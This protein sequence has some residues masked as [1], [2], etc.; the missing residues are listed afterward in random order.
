MSYI[1]LDDPIMMQAAVE[2]AGSFFKNTPPPVFVDEIQY[3]PN[4]FPYVKMII[5]G[6]KKKGQFYFSGS[7]QFHMMKNVSESL[8]GRIG[9]ANMLGLSL[10]EMKGVAFRGSFI[11]TEEYFAERRQ[12]LVP[13]GYREIWEIIHRGS[14]PELTADENISRHSFYAAYARTYVERD[15]RDLAQV[16]DAVAFMKFM[17]VIASMTG[18]LLNLSSVAR[19]V[20]ISAPTAERGLSVL[21][22]SDIV[23][24]LRPYS[25]NAVKRAVKTP[26]IYFLDTGL[27]AYLT[28]WTSPEVMEAEPAAGHNAKS[29]LCKS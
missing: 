21:A 5:D 14:M 17:A 20:G 8:A 3:A 24:L 1:T 10:R 4:L 15:V 2:E 25:N 7:Q 6:E 27:A 9:I 11:P 18:N 12:N 19:D 26:K 28:K 23:Y 16:G 22:A 13:S 29:Q